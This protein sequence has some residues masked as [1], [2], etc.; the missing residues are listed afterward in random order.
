MSRLRHFTRG[1][2]SS[3]LATFVTVVYALLSVPLA[4]KY[5]TVEEFGLL[6]LLQQVASYFALVDFGMTGATARL[7]IDHK[8]RPHDGRYGAFIMAGGAVCILQAAIIL[9]LGLVGAPLIVRAFSISAQHYD[10]AVYLLRWLAA[11][12]ALGS[13]LRIFSSVLYANRRVDLVVL[14]MSLVPLLGLG[15]M[16]LVLAGGMGLRGMAYAFF[17]PAVIAGTAC[18]AAVFWLGMMPAK[19]AWQLPSWHQFRE[20]LLLGKDMFL[21]NVGNQILEASQLMIVARTMGLGAAAV[22]SVSTKLFTLVFQLVT[23]VEGTAIVFFSEMMVRGER[24]RLALRFRNIYQLT[25]GL[26]VVALAAVAAI[27]PSFVTAWAKP[28]LAWASAFGLLMAISTYLNCLTKCQM[29]LIMHSKDIR[30]LRYVYFLEAVGFVI[31]AVLGSAKFGFTGIL[32]AAIVCALVFRGLYTIRRTADYFRIAPSALYWAWLRRSF[33]A[34][35]LLLPFVLF[36]PQIAAA[37]LHPWA[38]VALTTAWIGVPVVLVLTFVALPRDV[39]VE[40]A[41]RFTPLLRGA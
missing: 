2:A 3:W 27:N 31:L 20:M 36:A 24:E 13:A 32:G 4:L 12:F 29:D 33:L 14:F 35:A 9:I 37:A 26:A 41:G 16:W 11:G 30:S 7:L 5:L 25:A 22:W 23:K 15:F 18:V 40:I 8:D 17:P 1:V 34:A 39:R 38:A 10:V 6:V 21:I 28:E 19:G